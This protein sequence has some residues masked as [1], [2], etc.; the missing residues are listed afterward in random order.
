MAQARATWTVLLPFV[1]AVACADTNGLGT[2]PSAPGGV[3][4]GGASAGAG[5]GRGGNDDSGASSGGLDAGPGASVDGSAAAH[6]AATGPIPVP[7]GGYVGTWFGDPGSAYYA[8]FSD[9]WTAFVAAMGRPPALVGLPGTP[10]PAQNPDQWPTQ[11][12]YNVSNWPS[13]LPKTT[14]PMLTVWYVDAS[15]DELFTAATDGTTY[16][17]HD[18]DYWIAQML[19]PYADFGIKKIY[20][21]PAWEWNDGF[22]GQTIADAGAATFVT[23]MQRFYTAAHTWGAANGVT[24]RVAWN[25][26]VYGQDTDG[27]ALA[28]QFPDQNP[29]DHYVDVVAADF[30]AFGNSLASAP[31]GG[32]NVFT[33]TAMVALSQ[34]W[35]LP[36]GFCEL[37]GGLYMNA[38]P[39]TVWLP[40]FVHYAQ[41]LS[42]AS[43]P[44]PIEFMTLWD[45]ASIEWTP[46]DAGRADE[47]AGW[48]G[49]LGASGS[50]TTIPVQ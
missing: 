35:S 1:V 38:D 4:D 16:S 8:S 23:A 10:Y 37:G 32:P 31:L 5:G 49:A 20:L 3:T 13:A 15:N 41:T 28:A 19:Q 36:L 45:V 42:T 9:H 47:L 2:S 48:Q 11:S 25:P 18:V 40:D 33:L 30:Y 24:V 44:V 6:D 7:L 43:P 46:P 39:T 27:V 22:M 34:K 50:L 12:Q 26:S 17:G 21:R 14:S 29:S